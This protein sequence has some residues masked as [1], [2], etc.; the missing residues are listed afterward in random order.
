M[1]KTPIFFYYFKNANPYKTEF[2][3]CLYKVLNYVLI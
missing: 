3:T 1:G 2:Y